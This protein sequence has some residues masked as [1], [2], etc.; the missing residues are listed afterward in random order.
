M[1]VW[2]DG[3]FDGDGACDFLGHVIEQLADVIDEGLELSNS[4][5]E[6]PPLQTAKLGK[7]QLVTL[8]EPVVP[9]L[10]ILSAIVSKIPSARSCLE[11]R[12]VR[13][14]QQQ[15]FQWFENEY[16]L[17]NGTCDDY[18]NSIKREFRSLMKNL[19]VED[20]EADT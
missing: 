2:G 10:A 20:L 5:R 9:A 8:H 13:A 19:H 12:R 17:A 14:W 4:G 11:K 7:G 1:G 15:Y 6:C 16:V 3:I 18:Q